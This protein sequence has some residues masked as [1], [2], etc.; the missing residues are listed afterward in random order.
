ML[1]LLLALFLD[2]AVA[3]ELTP[4]EVEFESQGTNASKTFQVENK[5]AKD[6]AVELKAYKRTINNKGEEARQETNEFLIFPKQVK[7]QPS[8]KIAVRVVWQGKADVTSEL[9]Y[10]LIAEQLP[11]NFR[12]KDTKEKKVNIDFLL[13]YVASVYITPAEAKPNIVIEKIVKEKDRLKGTLKNL[14]NKHLVIGKIN[15]SLA[16]KPL[17][18]DSKEIIGRNILAEA[19][20]DFDCPWPDGL[21]EQKLNQVRANAD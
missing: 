13:K 12:K 19:S 2:A 16:G 21:D 14:G 7:L 8:K 1:S 17:S 9:S 20:F 10:R 11:V 6:I 18:V 4:M 5:Y 3:L 15:F